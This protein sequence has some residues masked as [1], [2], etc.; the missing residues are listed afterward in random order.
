MVHN[1][2]KGENI[3]DKKM[4]DTIPAI[5]T[6]AYTAFCVPSMKELMHWLYLI[7]QYKLKNLEASQSSK[8][9]CLQNSKKKLVIGSWKILQERYKL[10]LWNQVMHK[11]GKL[12][13]W[14]PN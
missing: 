3:F 7:K 4:C 9:K 8:L 14:F 11:L 1:I 6:M 12:E 2:V 13:Q 5:S 10:L